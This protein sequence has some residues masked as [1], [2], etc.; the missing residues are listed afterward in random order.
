MGPFGKDEGQL[1]CNLTARRLV[2]AKDGIGRHRLVLVVV[3]SRPSLGNGRAGRRSTHTA[4]DTSAKGR[5][6]RAAVSREVDRHGRL[7]V[8]AAGSRAEP[9]QDCQALESHGAV[10]ASKPSH[11][12]SMV[13]E[14]GKVV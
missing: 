1:A 6:V 13:H 12:T 4:D 10:A 3:V 7:A 8:G 14:E 5:P 9:G 2:R 11:G